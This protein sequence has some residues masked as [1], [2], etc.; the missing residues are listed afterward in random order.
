MSAYCKLRYKNWMGWTSLENIPT[1]F[2]ATVFCGQS[3]IRQ[4]AS[5]CAGEQEYVDKRKKVV[6]E[7]L[8]SLGINSSMVRRRPLRP[9]PS[10][11]QAATC[12]SFFYCLTSMTCRQIS[13]MSHMTNHFGL[14]RKKKTHSFFCPLMFIEYC[15]LYVRKFV[16]SHLLSFTPNVFD[17]GYRRPLPFY[18]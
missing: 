2:C 1:F 11:L 4:S 15:I 13:Q 7:S 5:L 14:I 17:K 12:K 16:F 6:L 3:L 18:N 10:W 8:N 9:T